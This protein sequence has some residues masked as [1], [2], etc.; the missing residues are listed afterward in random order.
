MMFLP[1]GLGGSGLSTFPNKENDLA[2]WV[3]RCLCMFLE[4]TCIINREMLSGPVLPPRLRLIPHLPESPPVIHGELGLAP[5]VELRLLSKVQNSDQVGA[6]VPGVTTRGRGAGR[7]PCFPLQD[8]LS[9]D[10]LA[11]SQ[12]S[13]AP[14]KYIMILGEL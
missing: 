11:A 10:I 2:Q 6:A 14:P 9:S 1:S 5:E 7:R 4:K 3:S 13:A 12:R 8:H